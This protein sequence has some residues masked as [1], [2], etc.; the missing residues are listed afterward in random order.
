M[1]RRGES[2]W[3]RRR[4]RPCLRKD[5]AAEAGVALEQAEQGAEAT[6]RDV[7]YAGDHRT[8]R[9]ERKRLVV[10]EL[11]PAQS[12][13]RCPRR[14]A[15]AQAI[16]GGRYLKYRPPQGAY[17]PSDGFCAA[18]IGLSQET[19]T[20]PLPCETWEFDGWPS[21]FAYAKANQSGRSSAARP[22][23]GGGFWCSSRCT[24]YRRGGGRC[25]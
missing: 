8:V 3:R 13:R 20:L 7:P 4:L 10:F 12:C 2:L 22:S 16:P 17:W 1:R 18:E 15:G 24:V 14:L 23:P 25:L 9:R 21:A 6:V 11:A 5:G 19:I